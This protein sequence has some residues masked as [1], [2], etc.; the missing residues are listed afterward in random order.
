MPKDYNGGLVTPVFKEG[1]SLN[2]GNYR[3]IAVT[4]P[5]LRLYA[6]ILNARLLGYTEAQGL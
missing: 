5:I 1:A 3:P 2:A 4:E 6:N